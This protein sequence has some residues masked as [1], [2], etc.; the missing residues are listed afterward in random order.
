MGKTAFGSS[1]ASARYRP[2]AQPLRS[3]LVHP[4]ELGR[5]TLENNLVLAPMAGVSNLPFR[6]L[7]REAGAALVF[8]ET[9]SA[10]GLVCGGAKSWRLLDTSPREAPVAFQIFGSDPAILG[11]AARRLAERNVEWIDL[12]MGCPVKKFIKGKAGSA[13]LRDPARVAA[14]VA[15]L[16]RNFPGTLSVKMRSGWD[17]DSVNAPEIARIAV[18]EGA[19]LISVHGRTRAQQ[20]TGRADRQVIRR[21]VEGVPEVP[22]LANGDI[23]LPEQVFAILEETG[24]AGVMIGRGAMGN[25]WIF[26]QAL[27]LARNE[28]LREP[29]AEDRYDTIQRHIGLMR[30]SFEDPRSLTQNLKKYVSAYAKGQ[31]ESSAFRQ[32]VNEASDLA[33]LLDLT[34]RFFSPA[35]RAV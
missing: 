29:S 27:A 34:E 28:A 17:H 18:A 21:V 8:S 5:I 3:D 6:L 19:E 25:P 33:I 31:A 13:L 2:P 12:N 14:V 23:T 7:A 26:A 11:E 1:A 16:R 35:E 15:A 22:V 32:R 30:S 24:A 20:Y 4:I 10:K 9:V